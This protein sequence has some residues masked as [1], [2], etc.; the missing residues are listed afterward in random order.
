MEL[1]RRYYESVAELPSLAKCDIIAHFDL[2]T[3]HAEKVKFFDEESAEYRGYA[4]EA[5]RKIAGKIPYFEVNVGGIARGYRST[6]YPAPYLAEEMLSLGMGA[7][8]GTDCHFPSM[9]D[10]SV[11]DGI[12]L[13]RSIGAGEVYVLGDEGFYPM[14]I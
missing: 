1:A 11:E 13:L 8:I 12:A 4:L 6:P 14:S 2:V 10:S 3:K 7:V 5:A 9:L